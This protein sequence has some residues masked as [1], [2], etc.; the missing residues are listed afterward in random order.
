VSRQPD[1]L[2]EGSSIFRRAA[3]KAANPEQKRALEKEI[4]FLLA[5]SNADTP[6]KHFWDH[7]AREQSSSRGT[8]K[9]QIR[10]FL[11]Y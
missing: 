7:G 9:T 3:H 4:E 5:D 2:H 8:P 11:C 10:V 6:T 1:H